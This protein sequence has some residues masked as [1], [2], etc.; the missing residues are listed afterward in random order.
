MKFLKISYDK[1]K[2][3]NKEGKRFNLL[4]CTWVKGER[5]KDFDDFNSLEEA[6]LSYGLTEVEDDKPR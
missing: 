2:Y 6:M 1:G 5:A 3:K 4:V